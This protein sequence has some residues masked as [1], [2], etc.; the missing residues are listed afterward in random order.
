MS[1][2]NIK[3][4][5]KVRELSYLSSY[6]NI[7]DDS[8]VL[9]ENC[10][11]ITECT[12]VLA[13]VSTGSFEVEIWGSGLSLSNYCTNCVEVRGQIQSVKLARTRSRHEE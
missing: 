13:R 1:R 11:Q 6:I 2:P 7:I 8:A 5:G 10:R 3:F 9:I 4:L 12:E